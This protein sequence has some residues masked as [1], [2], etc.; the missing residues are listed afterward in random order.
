M[1]AGEAGDVKAAHFNSHLLLLSSSHADIL[2]PGFTEAPRSPGSPGAEVR[3]QFADYEARLQALP[4]AI[5]RDS[6]AVVRL[7]VS[8]AN[9]FANLQTQKQPT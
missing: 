4:P 5:L 7:C 3:I 6:L 2:R 9:P 1:E 8:F